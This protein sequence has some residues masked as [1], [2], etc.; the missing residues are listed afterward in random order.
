MI[1]Q[2]AGG[3]HHDLGLLFQ[4]GDLLFDGLAAVQAH[5]THALLKCAQI[6]QF[7]LNLNGQLPGGG[8]HQRLH[9]VVLRVDM[10]H[11][12]DA[13]GKGLARAGGRLGD[14]VF[15][16]HEVG[17]RAGLHRCGLHITLFVN[18]AHDLR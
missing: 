5:G 4:L 8:K 13:E 14:H 1:H 18:G 2:A 15:P 7:L 17:N 11:H 16:L 6:P 10:L 12:G 3:G 9:I